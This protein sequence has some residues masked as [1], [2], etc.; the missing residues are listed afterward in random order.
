[1]WIAVAI[2]IGIMTG[3]I[4]AAVAIL[5]VTLAECAWERER[6]ELDMDDRAGRK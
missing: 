5:C 3:L 2:S 1:M 6:R 4:L